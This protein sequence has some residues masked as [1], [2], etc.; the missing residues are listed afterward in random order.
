MKTIIV[1]LTLLTSLSAFADSFCE[2]EIE[3]NNQTRQEIL[4]MQDTS[5]GTKA[6][7]LRMNDN[8]RKAVQITCGQVAVENSYDYCTDELAKNE[9]SRQEI[10]AMQDTSEETK[11][12]LLRMNDNAKKSIQIT[13][14]V[15]CK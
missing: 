15:V 6:I 8:A 1:G 7:L 11:S 10:L 12:I 4:A 5:K 14:G 2:R 13:M 3:K 9:V